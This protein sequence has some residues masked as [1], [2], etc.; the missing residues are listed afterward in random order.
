MYTDKQVDELQEKYPFGN[1][2]KNSLE[3]NTIYF[4][5]E[6]YLR[7]LTEVYIEEQRTGRIYLNFSDYEVNEDFVKE[8]V[9]K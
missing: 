5:V 2:K 3:D 7:L 1:I 8:F 4:E 9:K 6:R